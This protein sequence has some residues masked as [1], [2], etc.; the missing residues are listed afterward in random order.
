M[1]LT[2][3]NLK[4]YRTIGH[5]LNPIVTIATKGLTESVEAEISRALDDHE[6]VKIKV[7]I[8]DRA[9]RKDTVAHCC[10]NLNA[11]VVQEIGKVALIYRVSTKKNLRHSNVR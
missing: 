1:A 11:E 7:A 10:K 3:E 4:K 2:P 8:N 6:L 9:L 5:D